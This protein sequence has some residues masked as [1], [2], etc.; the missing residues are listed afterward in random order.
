MPGIHDCIVETL[1]SSAS[2]G[3]TVD[4]VGGSWVNTQGYETAIILITASAKSGTTPQLDLDVEISGDETNWHKLDDIP[5]INDPTVTSTY[6]HAAYE[7]PA[8]GMFLRVN[9]PVA[10]GSSDTLTIEV[11]VMLKT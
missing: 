1:F 7:V 9:N 4:T 11:K 5:Q 3:E 2:V 10:M 6:R 8:L